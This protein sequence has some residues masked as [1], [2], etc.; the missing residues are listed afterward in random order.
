MAKTTWITDT[1]ASELIGLPVA[2]LVRYAREK[3]LNIR[4]AKA[5]RKA[6]VRF[7]KEDIEAILNDSQRA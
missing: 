3:K 2:T 5:T 7:I 6:K 1:Q 4:T